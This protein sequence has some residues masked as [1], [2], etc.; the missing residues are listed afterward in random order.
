MVGQVLG[1][2][3]SLA[4]EGA[5]NIRYVGAPYIGITNIEGCLITVFAQRPR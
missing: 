3:A 4:L 5:A 1:Y 2:W